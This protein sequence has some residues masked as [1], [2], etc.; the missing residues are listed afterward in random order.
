LFGSPSESRNQ[1]NAWSAALEL[2]VQQHLVNDN[3]L[4]GSWLAWASDST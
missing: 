2:Q 4:T 1:W 3:N